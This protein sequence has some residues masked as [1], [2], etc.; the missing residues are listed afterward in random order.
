MG[1]AF[2]QS[3]LD[4][5]DWALPDEEYEAISSIPLQRR[6]VDGSMVRP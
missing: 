3:N 4:V 5:L 2:S 1:L 6:L